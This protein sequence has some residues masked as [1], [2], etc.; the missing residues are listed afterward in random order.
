MHT[1][2]HYK[3]RGKHIRTCALNVNEILHL[4]M[5]KGTAA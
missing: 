1:A 3:L 2:S 5:D 4:T